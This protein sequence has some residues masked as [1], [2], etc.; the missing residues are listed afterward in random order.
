MTYQFVWE[1]NK[2][3]NNYGINHFKIQY[4]VKLVHP[5]ALCDVTDTVTQQ[6]VKA[7]S[8][9]PRKRLV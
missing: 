4:V 7:N 8:R 1:K 3:A 2:Q 5:G 6:P 9:F